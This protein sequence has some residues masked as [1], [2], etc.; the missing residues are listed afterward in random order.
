MRRIISITATHMHRKRGA[1]LKQC[2]RDKTHFLVEKD[3]FPLVVL[4]PID[5]YRAAFPE[6]ENKPDEQSLSKPTRPPLDSSTP[7]LLDS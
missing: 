1:I 3:G 4:I 2:F 7:G 6:G 5:H